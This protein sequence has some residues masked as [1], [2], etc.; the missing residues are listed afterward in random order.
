[1]KC[2]FCRNAI[3]CFVG[4]VFLLSGF[5]KAADS[6]AFADLMSQYGVEWFGYAAP[7]II[8]SEIV[9]G[10]AL[11]F[12]VYVRS[13]TWV[14]LAFVVGVTIVFAYGL[15]F[16]GITDCGCFG[17]LKMLNSHPWFTFT[18][19]AFLVLLLIISL[20]YPPKTNKLSLSVLAFSMVTIGIA[21]YLCGFSLY[22][23]QIL[24][25]KSSPFEP[26]AL[27][28]TALLEFL[29]ENT[30]IALS[31]DSTYLVFAFSYTCP[32]CRNSIGNVEQY[33]R[34]NYVDRTIGL[35]MGEREDSIRFV[36][37]FHPDFEIHGVSNRQLPKLV[38]NL[39]TS[40]IIRHD[41][42]INVISGLAVSPSLLK[43][44]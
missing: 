35:A 22:G 12:R 6:A 13:V 11:V 34:M 21:A 28:E 17:Q 8:L 36:N 14:T 3:P 19:N 20:V 16:R 30:G 40:F 43:S 18:R 37:L 15:L 27:Q 1:M 39:P 5:L 33:E 26:K 29:I 9:L 25:A 2:S 32:Y 7:A 23:A 44:D 4:V 42:L 10:L 24:K 31:P 41:T 38:P